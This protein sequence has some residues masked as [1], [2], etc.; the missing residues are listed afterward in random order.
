[1]PLFRNLLVIP[2]NSSLEPVR[3]KKA[4]NDKSGVFLSGVSMKRPEKV[5]L[6]R[7]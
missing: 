1:M 3:S 7:G 5:V 2:E 4:R 6:H